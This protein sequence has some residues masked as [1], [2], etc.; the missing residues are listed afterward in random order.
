MP[1]PVAADWYAH[2][3]TELPNEFWR[4]CVPVEATAAEVDFIETR[5]GFAR[6]ARVLD[7]PCGSGRHALALAARGHAVLGVDISA[8]AIEHARRAASAAAVSV[9]WMVGELRQVP[10]DASFDAAICM[11]NSF[12]YL[13]LSGTRGFAV[14]LAGAVRPGGG[15][16]IDY[17]ATAESVLPGF[18]DNQ[19]RSI[20]AGDIHVTGSNRYDVANSRL[21]SRYVFIRGEQRFEAIALHHVYTVAQLR[22]LLLDVG[23]A[24]IQLY[25]GP[26]G[27]LFEV[28]CGRLMLTAVRS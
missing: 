20:N 5:L 19:P 2:F 23:F 8:E 26:E 15:L 11:G 16:V 17:G 14:A 25:S 18:T 6:G 10:Q 3:F 7:V 28:G 21:L 1:E 9:Q 27:K 22:G 12:G 4:R 24:N 13:D